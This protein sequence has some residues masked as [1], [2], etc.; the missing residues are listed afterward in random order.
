M[1]F[2]R[3]VGQIFDLDK[4][5]I[6]TSSVVLN[7]FARRA[8]CLF[9]IGSIVNNK[10]SVVY[11]NHLRLSASSAVQVVMFLFVKI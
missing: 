8:D 9:S 1:I 4:S 3:V 5:R 7:N 2:C 6:V 10:I 11:Q